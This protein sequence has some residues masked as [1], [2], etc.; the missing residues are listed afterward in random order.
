MKFQQL[1]HLQTPYSTPWMTFRLRARLS[2]PTSLLPVILLAFAWGCG[3]GTGT[4]G[5][6]PGISLLSTL[7]A[8]DT[9]DAPLPAVAVQVRDRGGRPAA[10]VSVHFSGNTA[11]RPC[12]PHCPEGPAVLFRQSQGGLAATLTVTTDADG[13]AHADAVL[14][15]VATTARLV[16]KV[17]RFD[18]EKTL[19]V[20]VLPGSPV[21]VLLSPADT[22]VFAGSSYT[23]RA[24]ATDRWANSVA[25]PPPLSSSSP[26][27]TI[28]GLQVNATSFAR[29]RINGSA[30]GVTGAA[31]VTVLP[32]ATI[33]GTRSAFGTPPTTVLMSLDGSDQ[34]VLMGTPV[35]HASGWSPDGTRLLMLYDV[36]DRPDRIYSYHVGTG[37]TQTLVD[38]VGHPRVSQLGLARYTADGQ[39]IWFSGNGSLWRMRPDG[40]ELEKVTVPT[41][42]YMTAGEPSPS[43]DAGRVAYSGRQGADD[44]W[45]A[46]FALDVATGTHHRLW[47]SMALQPRWSPT[48]AWIA[49][50]AGAIPHVIR[51][52]GTGH[53]EFPA[54]AG[55]LADWSP[56][57]CCLL[58]GGTTGWWLVGVETGETVRLPAAFADRLTHA[59]WRPT[60]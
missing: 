21:T 3:D 57:G 13:V 36:V 27:V 42:A 58:V 12:S 26:G 40:S 11:P 24:I 59:V 60:P 9:V 31:Q 39:W 55:W 2:G 17:P 52:D 25:Q 22:M 35:A 50:G 53:R 16:V 46:L 29:A 8:A 14:G 23:L 54:V 48:G 49:F 34:Q 30:N 5:E 6:Q 32:R 20:S 18:Y 19:S 47:N 33:A 37:A 10:G 44:D 45:H 15:T 28:Q 1:L 51:P 7:P 4:T 38:V 43:P 56:D 41:S